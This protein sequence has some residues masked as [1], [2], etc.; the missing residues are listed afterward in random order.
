M[1]AGTADLHLHSRFSDG[2]LT[3]TEIVA[4]AKE[5][6]LA[7]IALTD[8]DTVNGIP[9]AMRAAD[10]C[11]L[12]L[13]S[14]I[15]LSATWEGKDIHVLGYF[16]DIGCPALLQALQRFVAA[17]RERAEKMVRILQSEGVEIGFDE[18]IAEAGEGAFGRPH[19]ATVLMRKGYAR[20]VYD[21][22]KK[23]LGYDCIAY[24]EKFSVTPAEAIELIHSANGLAFL[25]HPSFYMKEKHYMH[26]IESGIDGIETIHPNHFPNSTEHF[27]RLVQR[28]HLLECGGSDCHGRADA[29]QIGE[30][31]VPYETV[32]RM[33]ERLGQFPT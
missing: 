21:V 22:F 5:K 15:E 24:V 1:S 25:A 26:V 32:L 4:L 20:N 18:V 10:A 7:A 12:E 16:I 3:P 23:Y 33:K 29:L 8:H 13:I 9:E 28:Y 30:F 17:R 19:I 27:R 14:G 2:N 11:N 31:P 6:N